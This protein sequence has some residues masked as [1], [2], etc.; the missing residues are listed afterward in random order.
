LI[1]IDDGSSD[2]TSAMVQATAPEAVVIRGNG[3]LWW[4][5]CLQ[6]GLNWLVRQGVPGE[7]LVLMLNDDTTFDDHLVENA[8]RAIGASPYVMLLAQAYSSRTGALIE[9]GVRAD[10]RTLRFE[11][12]S[13]IGR[14]NCVSTRGLFIRL[15]DALRVGGFR[16]RLLPHY[17]SDYEFTIRAHRKGVRLITDPAARLVV[18]EETTGQRTSDKTSVP[19]YLRSVFT[20]RSTGNPIYWTTFLLMAC[21]ARYL[22]VNVLRVWLGFMSGLRDALRGQDG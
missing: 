18:N 7:E 9:V 13:E 4:A 20:R 14:A 3:S 1:V 12:V 22:P 2:G 16:P 15:G 21:P 17:L 6:K 10:W 19:A 11:P 8:V 5:G